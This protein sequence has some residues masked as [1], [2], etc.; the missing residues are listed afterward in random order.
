MLFLN[1]GYH[2]GIEL[3]KNLNTLFVH[4]NL[5]VLNF[6]KQ[7]LFR[8]NWKSVIEYSISELLFPPPFFTSTFSKCIASENF[9]I[10]K[11]HCFF[12]NKVPIYIFAKFDLN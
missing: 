1:L 12:V 9:S 7:F 5:F 8:L 2:L 6:S 4:H 3:Q 10:V 11:N